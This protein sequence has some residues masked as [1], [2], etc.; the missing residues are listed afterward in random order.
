MQF[1]CIY[2]LYKADPSPTHQLHVPNEAPAYN[3]WGP[4]NMI[5]LFCATDIMHALLLPSC[6]EIR[7]ESS[8]TLARAGAAVTHCGSPQLQ[9]GGSW[10]SKVHG[11]DRHKVPFWMHIKSPDLP[12]QE[13]FLHRLGSLDIGFPLQF[14]SFLG[15][16]CFFSISFWWPTDLWCCNPFTHSRNVFV[17]SICNTYV[18]GNI[19]LRVCP[20]KFD[21]WIYF[22]LA[23]WS[24]INLW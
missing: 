18:V 3:R 9:N 13:H 24:G 6:L 15:K 23:A 19:H 22:Y 5:R 21:P 14:R 17:S 12:W 8:F 1:S 16:N 20:P 10:A 7:R 2:Y 11:A 4:H